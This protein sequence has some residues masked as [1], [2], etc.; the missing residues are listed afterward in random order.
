M[1]KTIRWALAGL[2][3]STANVFAQSTPAPTPAPVTSNEQSDFDAR[4]RDVL[5]R[6][7]EILL[8]VFE[9][10]ERQQTAEQ[11]AGDA[12]LIQKH[13]ATLFAGV[14]DDQPVLVEFLDY[15]CGYCAKAH[16]EVAQLRREHPEIAVIEI[17]FPILGDESVSL[18]RWMLGLRMVHGQEAFLA[19]QDAL[20]AGDTA[21]RQDFLGYLRAQ[22]HD[23]EAIT[24]KAA[25]EEVSATIQTGY[26]LAR[27]L[28]ITGT[29]G[30]VTRSAIIRGFVANDRLV[31]ATTA[32]AP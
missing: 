24:A 28:N 2:M 22:G 1:S 20:F 21:A 17:Q 26:E 23:V 31:A 5:L 12:A 13:A 25:S 14:P 19:A 29:P 9:I 27:G 8:E 6:N 16:D 3:L 30:F 4:V 18:S 7:P 32:P 11:S 10:L 15:R